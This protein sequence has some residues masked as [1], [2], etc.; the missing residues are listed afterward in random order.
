MAALTRGPQA[1]RKVY[2]SSERDGNVVAVD[3]EAANRQWEAVPHIDG[4]ILFRVI[5]CHNDFSD[6]VVCLNFSISNHGSR[7][8][9][10][11]D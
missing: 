3:P 2:V 1:G 4:D 8:R 10:L 6:L 5:L 9:T 11:S 7:P